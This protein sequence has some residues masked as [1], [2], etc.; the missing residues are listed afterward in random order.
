MNLD[1]PPPRVRERWEEK[2]K[3]IP[4]PQGMPL[5]E[6]LGGGTYWVTDPEVRLKEPV[7]DI[8]L[9][10]AELLVEDR[11]GRRGYWATFDLFTWGPRGWFH[12]MC[13]A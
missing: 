5:E 12:I 1:S 6:E 3:G 9:R 4:R 2:K 10:V 8:F 13:G 7:L 11:D